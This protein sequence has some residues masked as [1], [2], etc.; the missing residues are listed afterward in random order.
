MLKEDIQDYGTLPEYTLKT[1]AD[2]NNN[3]KPNF[4]YITKELEKLS[5]TLG[6]DYLNKVKFS[7]KVYEPQ[8]IVAIENQKWN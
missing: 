8:I 3:D 7:L 2:W 6:K 1:I 4:T 5:R